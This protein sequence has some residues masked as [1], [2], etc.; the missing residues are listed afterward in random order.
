M[1]SYASVLVDFDHSFGTPAAAPT[2]EGASLEEAP[3]TQS[4]SD[5]GFGADVDTLLPAQFFDGAPAVERLSGAR[6]LMM[7]ILEDAIGC[8]EGASGGNDLE[9]RRNTVQAEAWIRSD[10]WEWPCSFNN[11]CQ[12]LSLEPALLRRRLLER[13][14]VAAAHPP[15]GRRR[16]AKAPFRFK[17]MSAMAA[18]AS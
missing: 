2:R 9:R 4:R 11:V 12:S 6:G 7:A 1:K 5:D 10:D 17:R 13:R 18:T 15:A 8:L 16:R 14:R 3:R